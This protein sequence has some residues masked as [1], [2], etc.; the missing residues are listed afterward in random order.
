MKAHHDDVQ[1]FISN[2]IFEGVFHNLFL[3]RI[4]EGTS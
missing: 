1:K 3:Q 2:K 4:D